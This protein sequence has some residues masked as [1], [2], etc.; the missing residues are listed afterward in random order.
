MHILGVKD[1]TAPMLSRIEVSSVLYVQERDD[2][3]EEALTAAEAA[4]GVC[5]L[6]AVVRGVGNT[7]SVS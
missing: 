2:R 7:V 5:L 3:G 6:M 4:R 1:S